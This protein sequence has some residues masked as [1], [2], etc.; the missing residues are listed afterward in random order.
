MTDP[1]GGTQPGELLAVIGVLL[2][3]AALVRA[4]MPTLAWILFRQRLTR[5]ITIA[6]ALLL[7]I[8]CFAARTEGPTQ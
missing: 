5:L 4:S 8:A 6:L 7:L 1:E 2:L 3:V